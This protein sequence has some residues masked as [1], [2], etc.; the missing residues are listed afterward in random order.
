MESAPERCAGTGIQ[1]LLILTPLINLRFYQR[2]CTRGAGSQLDPVI[3]PRIVLLCLALR[4]VVH[5]VLWSPAFCCLGIDGQAH[6]LVFGQGLLLRVLFH[7]DG[8]DVDPLLLL[9]E[10]EHAGTVIQSGLPQDS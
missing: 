9:T 10:P 5:I 2:M 8:H 7:G 3:V 1:S 4:L 6:I